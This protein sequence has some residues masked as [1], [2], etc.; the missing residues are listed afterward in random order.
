MFFDYNERRRLGI[1]VHVPF[2][3]G[4]C[5]YCDFNS[6]VCSNSE[7]MK[8]YV[9]ALISHMKSYRKVCTDYSP[10]TVFIGGGTPTA[11]PREELVRLIKGIKKNF[12]LTKSAEFTVE[13]N[14]A[15]VTLS[16]LKQLRRLGVN[17]LSMGLQSADNRELK[18]LSRLHTRQQ[19]VES[20]KMAREAKFDNI[21][22]DVMFGIP[23]Q[24]YDS[25]MKTLDFVT[26]LGP[27]HISLYNLKIEPGTPF[28]ANRDQLRDVCADEDTEFAMYTAAIEFLASRG[29][30]QYEIS[31][32][33][34]PGYKCLHNLK[35]WSCE[36]YLGFGVSA[37]S[38]FN[39]T[40]F[41]FIPDI[42]KYML[43]I[44]D[45]SSSIELVSES[46][47]LERRERMGEYI[48]LRFR[49][50]DGLDCSE[51]AARFGV[52]FENLYGAKT[53]RYVRDGFI[54]K[55]GGSYSLTPAGMFVSNYI[56]S[57]ILEF[58]DLG[59]YLGN[60]C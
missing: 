54:V 55:R 18:S 47:Q 50:T 29:Y 58:E 35:Y 21:N 40:R 26:R 43:A 33:A 15:T 57:D 14:P 24:T 1:Y 11:L 20:F 48:M 38:F 8:R 4:K 60:Y 13:A 2:C 19:F 53:E 36:E 7:H 59:A 23:Y 56:L 39:G 27:E 31:N 22:V 17:R 10:D 32:F 30:P 25:L 5:A 16:Q 6:T 37:H 44:E 46:E 42:T 3:K 28:F 49:L 45:M 34:R 52:S 9:S 51:F 12:D 41:A